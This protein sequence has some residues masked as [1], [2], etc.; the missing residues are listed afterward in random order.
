MVSTEATRAVDVRGAEIDAS[1]HPIPCGTESVT[2][3]VG[4]GFATRQQACSHCVRV[5]VPMARERAEK[6]Y[7]EVE[8]YEESLRAKN[9]ATRN[10]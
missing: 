6:S 7:S 8:D 4:S 1:G 3:L 10:L 9:L 2:T 5:K